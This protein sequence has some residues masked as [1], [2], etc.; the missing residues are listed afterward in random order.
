MVKKKVIFNDEEKKLGYNAFQIY[1]TL[2]GRESTKEA[3][4]KFRYRRYFLELAFKYNTFGT[5]INIKEYIKYIVDNNVP[6]KKWADINTFRNFL[7]IYTKQE[8]KEDAI[9]RSIAFLNSKGCDINT[10][11]Y[12]RLIVYLET[13]NVS[14]WLVLTDYP[15]FFEEINKEQG[16]VFCR[17]LLNYYFWKMKINN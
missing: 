15:E 7:L 12:N 1:N 8:P 4:E 6:A 16:N 11:S 17:N 3:F 10:I 2:K 14:P 5:E 9:N 13:G